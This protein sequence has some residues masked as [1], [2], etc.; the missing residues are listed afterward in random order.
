MGRADGDARRD[1]EPGQPLLGRLPLAAQR[2]RP[3]VNPHRT[4]IRSGLASAVHRRLRI[5]RR[6]RRARSPCPSAAASIISPMIERP[7]TSVPFLRTQTS[8][9]NCAAVLTKR[10][11]AR[12]CSPRLVA[13]RRDAGR[14]SPA[15]ASGARWLGWPCVGW[16]IGAHRRASAKQLRGDVDVFAAGFLRA[17]HGA[18]EA[19]AL[20][21]AGELDQ[22]RQVD[23]GDDLDLGAV[24]DRDGQV[25]RRAAEH[26]GQQHGALAGIDLRRSSAGC[27]GGAAPCRHRGRCRRRRSASAAP[28]TC[29]SA[30]TNSAASRPWVTK[31]MPIIGVA[32]PCATG[33]AARA[34]RGPCNGKPGTSRS[35]SASWYSYAGQKPLAARAGSR[36]GVPRR[37]Y[38]DTR[39]P[40]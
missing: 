4:C 12:A 3:L 37:E 2:R 34:G 13:D 24:H 16:P 38:G 19:L 28:T 23:A 18:L 21:Q 27:P 26:V 35:Q 15:A 9:S 8:A 17:E 25:G 32:P 30:A 7:E 31:T 29:S 1:A 10:A 6:W 11:A 39:G 40:I 22:H 5:A 33:A 36:W 20:A 14:P